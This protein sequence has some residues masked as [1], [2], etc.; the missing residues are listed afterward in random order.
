MSVLSSLL[1]QSFHHK[2]VLVFFTFSK[3]VITSM[4]VLSS[5]LKQS[6][7][8]QYVLVNFTFR[9]VVITSM[10][11]FSSLLAKLSSPVCQCFHQMVC[12]CYLHFSSPGALRQCYLHFEQSFHH[13]YDSVI[14]TFRKVAITSMSV[15]SS[16]LAKLSSPVSVFSSLLCYLHF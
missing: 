1:N 9:K 11:L 5:L 2:Y 12:H 15:L 7:H 14:F 3:L 8:H 10:S 6:C 16:L 4:S 13:Q